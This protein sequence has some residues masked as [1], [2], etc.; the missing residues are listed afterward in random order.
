MCLNLFVLILLQ[1]S[2]CLVCVTLRKII[3]GHSVS[4]VE[5]VFN[6]I[7]LVFICISNLIRIFTFLK[8]YRQQ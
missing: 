6:L 2:L 8:L 3:N 1:K 4:K 5:G 7:V